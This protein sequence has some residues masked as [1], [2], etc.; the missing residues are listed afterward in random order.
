MDYDIS[1][2]LRPKCKVCSS[3]IRQGI[4]LRLMGKE[5]DEESG[6]R[7]SY[8]EIIDWAAAHGLQISKAGLSRHKGDHLMPDVLGAIEAQRQ[9]EAIAQATG[10]VLGMETAFLN[11]LVNKAIRALDGANLDLTQKGAIGGVVRAIET[12]LKVKKTE[13]AFS[14]EKV[15]EAGKKLASTG[16]NAGISEE[17]L[18]VILRDVY[19]LIDEEP[20]AD[21]P[22]PAPTA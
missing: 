16:R 12:L 11:M 1:A 17:T 8:E 13:V 19:G 21:D 2:L 3:S 18:Q 10:Q 9:V 14:R 20:P 4:D 15:K 5:V 7:L 22:E 6:E